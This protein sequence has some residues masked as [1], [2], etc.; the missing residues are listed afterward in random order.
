MAVSP[1]PTAQ[2]AFC[3]G[4]A[5]Q[6]AKLTF[7]RSWSESALDVPSKLRR[8]TP[9]NAREAIS[10]ERQLR[11]PISNRSRSE[12]AL[13]VPSNCCDYKSPNATEQ[14]PLDL[15]SNCYCSESN[16][17]RTCP[18]S[19][20]ILLL[21]RLM[22]LSSQDLPDLLLLSDWPTPSA[23]GAV[24]RIRKFTATEGRVV[25]SWHHCS[26][27]LARPYLQHLGRAR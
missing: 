1:S 24:E 2:G 17:R 26:P 16:I 4:R 25:I 9:S 21:L 5:Q 27:G 15:P 18:A 7:N 19:S 3:A 20:K 23:S 22:E 10:A 14:P 11:H 6:S 12:P 13:D 8:S